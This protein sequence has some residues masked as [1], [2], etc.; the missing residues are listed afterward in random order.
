M[1]FE[2]SRTRLTTIEVPVQYQNFPLDSGNNDRTG[3]DAKIR[4]SKRWTNGADLVLMQLIF[5]GQY[6]LG[7]NYR[8]A[9]VSLPAFFLLDLPVFRW[10]GLQNSFSYE[11]TGQ[12]YFESTEARKDLFLK[13]GTGLTRNIGQTWNL[14]LEV[15]G[16][17]NLSVLETARYSKLLFTAQLN[18]Q[19]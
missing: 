18:H 15:S 6:S 17:K 10:I 8:I 11:L 1:K 19:F 5:D 7:R 2:H 13:A 16:Q 9:G 3:A 14:S 4:I 12:Y